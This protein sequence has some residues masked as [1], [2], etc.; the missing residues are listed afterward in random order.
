M[1]PIDR[2]LNFS[3]CVGIPDSNGVSLLNRFVVKPID[4]MVSDDGTH[5]AAQFIWREVI[6]RIWAV[7]TP[8]FAVLTAF[9]HAGA[10]IVKTPLAALK[11]AGIKQIPGC[12]SFHA[13]WDNVQNLGQ[14]TTLTVGGCFIGITRPDKIGQYAYP[15]SE[16]KKVPI[17]AYHEVSDNI[18]DPWTVSPETFRSHLQHLYDHNYEL[19]TLKELCEGYKAEEGKKLAVITFDDSHESQYRTKEINAFPWNNYDPNCAIGIIEEFSKK[20]SDFRVKATFFVNTSENPGTSG[21]KTHRIFASN[22]EEAKHTVVKLDHLQ[23]SGQEIAAHGHLHR[24]F[25]QMSQKE[26]EED[27]ATFIENFESYGFGSR[28]VKSFAWPHGLSPSDE[29]RKVI[30]DRFDNVADFGL[31]SG[32]EDPARMDRKRI[33]RLYIGPNTAFKQYAP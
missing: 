18:E 14:A 17:F 12:C 31:H 2:L 26:I 27:L 15:I 5:K 21:N 20:Y 32:K 19:C 10:I 16:R 9:Y 29:R 4:W 13:I 8:V 25:D 6:A 1:G 3:C 24:R 7:T 28:I 22:L 23:N 11:T 30:D 33:R